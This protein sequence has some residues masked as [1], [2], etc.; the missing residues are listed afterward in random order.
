MIP[1]MIVYGL[2]LGRWWRVA[3]VSAALVWPL[4]LVLADVPISGNGLVAAAFLG[5]ANASAGVLVHQGVLW[6]VRRLRAD[7]KDDH[8]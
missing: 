1:T 3:I 2:L 7:R 6:L 5:A 8:R 4:L